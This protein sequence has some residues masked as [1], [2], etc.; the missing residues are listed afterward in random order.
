MDYTTP[1]FGFAKKN[2]LTRTLLADWRITSIS[3]TQSGQLLATPTSS[4]SIGSYVSTGFTRMVRVPNVPLYLKDVNCGCIDP[5]Q[6]TVLNP[7]AW[8]NQAAGVPGSNVAYY[9]DFRAQRRPVISGGIGKVFQIREGMSFSIR[10]EFFNLFNMMESL[11]N[12]STGSPQNPVTRSNGVLTGGFGY[13][14]YTGIAG[15][16]VSS[17]LP[18]PRTGQIVARFQF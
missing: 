11:A 6:E 15:N 17:S 16:S 13:L 3:T 4:N 10:A 5:T 12:P 8:Q 18:T 2:R 14:N 7:A 9:N 1:S